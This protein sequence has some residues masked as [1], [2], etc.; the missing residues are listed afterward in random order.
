[1]KDVIKEAV[2]DSKNKIIGWRWKI[3]RVTTPVCN[4]GT[5][6]EKSSISARVTISENIAEKKYDTEK[7]N[8][9]NNL[10][11]QIVNDTKNKNFVTLE[12]LA[13]NQHFFQS[14]SDKNV[15]LAQMA[16]ENQNS[17]KNKDFFS[18]K[19]PVVPEELQKRYQLDNP[20]LYEDAF[21]REIAIE[22]IV[23]QSRQRP[24]KSEDL[25]I[26][27]IDGVEYIDTDELFKME[28]LV[29]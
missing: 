13:L 14:Y 20:E 21:F 11:E 26:V 15:T 27:V 8:K 22:H 17:L 28:G 25:P 24:D 7:P 19:V 5:N 10:Q 18:L 3:P 16:K 9:I 1:L 23:S 4:S 2:R 29:C 12:N 6:Q